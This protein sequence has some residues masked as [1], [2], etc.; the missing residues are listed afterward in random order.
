MYN[1][2]RLLNSG[3]G[4]NATFGDLPVTRWLFCNK[5]DSPVNSGSSRYRHQMAL[6]RRAQRLQIR[7]DVSAVL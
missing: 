1:I 5:P 6:R 3:L 7:N 4:T 2:G